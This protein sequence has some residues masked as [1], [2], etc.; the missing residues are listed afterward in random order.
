MD[1]YQWMDLSEKYLMPTYRR[2]PVVL[3]RGEGTRVWD[4]EGREYLDFGAGIAVCNLGHCHPRIVE[5]I[6]DQAECLLH[7]S[8]LYHIVPQIELARMLV[9]H[10]FAD[11]VFFCNSGAEANE[12]AIKLARIYARKFMDSDRY[13]IITMRGSFHGRTMVTLAAT[14]Q[15]KV[16]KGFAPLPP[17]FIH[18][19]Y[20]DLDSLEK[21]IT[22]KTCGVMLEVVQGEGGVMV[23]SREYLHEVARLCRERGLLLILDEVQTG[24]GRLGALLGHERFGITPHIVTLAKGLGGGVAIGALLATE[25][26]AGAFEPGTHA[27][28]FG[29]NPLACAAGKAV[30]EVMTSPGFLEGVREKGEYFLSH[31]RGLASVKQGIKEARGMG[32]MLALEL[33]GE[34]APVIAA[35]MER[36]FLTIPS[37]ERVVRFLPPLTVKKEEIALL[38]AALE[39]VLP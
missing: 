22:S 34:A 5:A 8:N 31:L 18:V 24:M 35:L 13:E 23:P 1:T 26:V 2:Y 6:K 10:T 21:A 17:G 30:M 39:E 4:V 36:G 11:R 33:E 27:S 37:G 19:P 9:E 3:V 16:K 32:L 28:T 29:G 20:G 25:E 7:V 12:G 15:E 38:L 14:G